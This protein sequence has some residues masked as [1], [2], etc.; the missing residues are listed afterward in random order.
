MKVHLSNLVEE[1]DKQETIMRGKSINQE[2]VKM[3]Q[4]LQNG[5][6][7]P[8]FHV[9]TSFSPA[10]PISKVYKLSQNARHIPGWCIKVKELWTIFWP[11]TLQLPRLFTFSNF[12]AETLQALTFHFSLFWPHFSLFNFLTWDFS[13][14]ISDTCSALPH[15]PNWLFKFYKSDT[16]FQVRRYFIINY[17]SHM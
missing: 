3:G 5:Q 2:F 8:L 6:K 10:T 17:F 16:T 13:S 7:V 14:L 1:D 11:E 12:C 9:E 15:R 4:K